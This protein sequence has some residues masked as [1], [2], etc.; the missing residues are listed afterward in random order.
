MLPRG[1]FVEF[2]ARATLAPAFGDTVAAWVQMFEQGLVSAEEFRVAVL[3]LSQDD[4]VA[5]LTTPPSAGASP[6]QQA[7]GVIALRPTQAVNA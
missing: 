6:S 5:S 7:S 1:S 3:Q 4:D 2:D